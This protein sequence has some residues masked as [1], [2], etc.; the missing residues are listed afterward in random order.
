VL[1]V[2]VGLLFTPAAG[3]VLRPKLEDELG[4]R[5]EGGSLRLNMGGDIVLR[6]V[7]FRVPASA[8]G[9]G[10]VGESARFLTIHH[11]QILLWWR[12]KIRG[13]AL[14]R[15]VEVFDADIRLSKPLDEFDLN[16][17]AI[18]PPAGAAAGS[19]AAG[20]L[21]GIVV[22][23]ANILL[24][25]HD[26]NGDIDELRTLP[27]VASLRSS[28]ETPGVYEVTA[29]EDPQLSTSA[30]PLKFEGRLGSDGFSGR[31][32]AID[33]ADFP[34]S[35]IPR[36]LRE[37][38]TELDM[39]GQTR[40][41]TVRYDEAT[42]VLELVLDLQ[43]A[44]PFPAPF[45]DDSNVA[46]R[47]NLRLPVPTD[48]AGTLK[49][50]IPVSGSGQLRLVQRPAPRGGAGVS[51]Q[52]VQAPSE[53]GV[54]GIGQRTLM[55]EG[56]LN[57]TIEDA[58]AN[59]DMRLWLGGGEPLYQFDVATA[60]PYAF[61]PDTPW[62]R[63][64]APVLQKV[65][66][67]I[68]LLQPRGTISLS[69]RVAQV[70][71]GD[72]VRQR[73]AGRGTIR[74][75][76]MQFE[77]FP[78][79]VQ[80]VTGSIEL[81]DGR[82]RL[83]G[84][85]GATPSGSPVLASTTITLDEVATGVEVDVQAFGVPYDDTLRQTLDDVAPEIRQILLNEDALKRAYQ[86][87][88]IRRPGQPGRAPAFG[89]GGEADAH[90]NV[91]RRA[92][93]DGSTTVH[94]DVRSTNFGLLPE[95]FPIPIIATDVLLTIDLP[96][97]LE[98]LAKGLPR[99][100]RVQAR[101]A[102]ATTV[103]GGQAEASV[104]V[105]V[106]L[107]E[108]EGEERST[109]VDV[110][111]DAVD[112]PVHDAMLAAVPGKGEE[113]D[114]ALPDG[115]RGLLRALGPRGLIDTD[116]RLTRDDRG[117]ID[118]W[119]E[120][121]PKGVMLV[122]VPLDR[123]HP[124]TIENLNGAVRVDGQ[125]L[126]GELAGRTRRGGD[127]RAALRADFERDTVLAVFNSTALNLESPVE[128][129]V[130]VVAP[131]VARSLAEARETFDVRG[132]ADVS[133][134]VRL[135]DGRASA[136]VRVSRVD[137]LRFDW[138]EGRMGLDN[139]RGAI[140]VTTT[141]N[142][143]LV[144]FDRVLA[145]GTY[146]GESVGRVRLRGEI[147]VDALRDQGS[148]F[149]RPTTLDLEVQGGTLESALL[150]MLASNRGGAGEPSL[151]DLWN[152]RGEYDALVSLRTPAYPGDGPGAKPLRAFELSP[153]EATLVRD[154]RTVRVPWISG[155]V[156][157]QE[158]TPS[159]QGP[160]GATAYAGRVDYLTLGGDDWWVS[161]DGA[162]HADGRGHTDLEVGLDGR[163]QPD[164]GRGN[165]ASGVPSAILGVMPPALGLAL[166]A[167]KLEST[168][169]LQVD[170]GRLRVESF[171]EA[172]TRIR[173]DSTLDI[174]SLRVGERAAKEGD[175]GGARPIARA[176]GGHVRV[177][178]DT[179]HPAEQ[180][181][182]VFAADAAQAWDLGLEG[183]EFSATINRNRTVD[184]E[185]ARA[186]GGGGRIAG[187]GRVFLP[188][189]EGEASRYEVDLAGAGLH[190]EWLMA[191]FQDREAQA[192]RGAGD[193]DLSVGLAATLGEPSTQRGR[194][195]MR[196]RGGSP[197]ALPLAIR[198]AVE[199]MNVNFGADEY[200][201]MNGEFY[202]IGQTMTFTR[203]AVSS[204]AVIL[205][206]L[207]TVDLS[208]GGLD[209]SITTKSTQDTMIRSI[210]RALR[211]VIVAVQLGG[212]L[213]N[214]APAPKPQ[215]LVGP[216]DRLRRMIQGGLTYEEWQRERLRRYARQQGEPA[217][218]W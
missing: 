213:E 77:H 105:S 84:L 30:K 149:E 181:S 157:G 65:S 36:Q 59:I 173:F 204:D 3:V 145:D 72:G 51:W 199:A 95:A 108:P 200:D 23:K 189:V 97:E 188:E 9:S 74:D 216:L 178:S 83:I 153:Y 133:T 154:G 12:A 26:A 18:E 163:I 25:E 38:Y 141:D 201:A 197:I 124:L 159:E 155:V 58:H 203:L 110:V 82:I 172:E 195:S 184:I 76:G 186:A 56:R 43:E 20:P 146:E 104:L 118:W 111:V 114:A 165:R 101:G 14:V 41:A 62:L 71:N 11:G 24:G 88:L 70:A 79:P 138:L 68:A 16:I 137:G 161:L 37:V 119:A 206:G 120:V 80:G 131:E 96:P 115:P 4:V 205:S 2:G 98:T 52:S 13:D 166:E 144:T 129:A 107:G 123:R 34:P 44:S 48:E 28:R 183:V 179:A 64:D 103:A 22:H 93:Y 151:L 198:A 60:E 35:T 99:A 140:V 147:P 174:E 211:E 117:E 113:G 122:P 46:A 109:T 182:L 125:G 89:L 190:T 42:G 90:V 136:E 156:S 127:V 57:S 160:G 135:S 45:A 78:Y 53:P 10:P 170:A 162:W 75:G 215:A 21:P 130:A 134:S 128:D 29:I 168:G 100:L 214:P 218:G 17:L 106:P 15:R 191:A 61:T 139:G 210:V 142:G 94:V 39:G 143:P 92:G 32:G 66:T 158:L 217:S 91:T 187:R 192:D 1:A 69:A 212:T 202:V 81:D 31:L 86:D 175:Q 167:M 207:G 7:T 132:I 150:R 112:V 209:M 169:A 116:F 164:S 47:L 152:V 194:G 176:Q 50:L 5:V 6:D 121:S 85:R 102:R 185:D 49:P 55:V 27:L 73:V 196:I 208:D 54:V 126:R 19:R 177:E 87:N 180:A 63:R 193:L 40:G 8:D 67:I 171:P 148:T 33:M